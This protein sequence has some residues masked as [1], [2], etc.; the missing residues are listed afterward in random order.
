MKLL[1][2]LYRPDEGALMIDDT[3]IDESNEEAYQ[4]LFSVVFSDFYLFD[5]LY[6]LGEVDEDEVNAL[7]D[8][9]E[10]TGKTRLVDGEFETVDL[11]TGQRKRL[12]LLVTMMED[13]PIC[14]FDEWAAEQD[15]MF[16][17]RFYRELLPR[18]KDQGKTIIAVTHDDKYFDA[19]DRLLQMD[20]GKLIT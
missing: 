10:L 17:R 12:A 18:L 11:S 4:N 6:G 8:D 3:V 13:K 16:R 9:L 2:A 14:V 1:T 5:R 15:P 19:A 7:I 20:E